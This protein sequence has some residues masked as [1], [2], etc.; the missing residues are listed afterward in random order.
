MTAFPDVF[1]APPEVTTRTDPFSAFSPES[2]LLTERFSESPVILL[3]PTLYLE[4]VSLG[5]DVPP[6]KYV[7]TA[8]AEGAQIVCCSALLTTTMPV[9][10]DVVDYAKAKGVR[11]QLT[12]MIG[13]API[14]DAYCKEIGADAYTSDA[15][16]AAEVALSFFT[17]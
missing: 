14:T 1:A 9:M 15:A 3:L 17:A 6:E 7:D 5:V 8:I 11:D 12:I 4:L 16:S 10:K 2:R 13:G